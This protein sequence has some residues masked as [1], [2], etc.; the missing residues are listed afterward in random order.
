MAQVQLDL[1]ADQNNYELVEDG[2]V[3]RRSDRALHGSLLVT[4]G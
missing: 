4:L 2:E 1:N 3:R